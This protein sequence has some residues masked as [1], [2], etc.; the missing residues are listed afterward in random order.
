MS[1]SV[2]VIAP[3][4]RD[5]K[6]LIKK[7]P[8]I[9]QDISNLLDSLEND[10]TQGTSLGHGCYKIRL[11]IASKGQGKSGG[12]RVITCVFAVAAEVYLLA[13]YDKSARDSISDAEL[14]ALVAEIP[15]TNS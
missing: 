6:R 7:Y 9:R 5:L 12:A 2:E 13:I 10:P 15:S 3:F 14:L 4:R 11:R 1:Y 8:S